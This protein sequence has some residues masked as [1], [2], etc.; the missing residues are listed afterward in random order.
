MSDPEYIPTREQI[1]AARE[2]I[3]EGWTETLEYKR[4]VTKQQPYE[5]QTIPIRAAIK[6]PNPTSIF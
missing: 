5:F 6:R 1:A 2:V 4:R 3:Q